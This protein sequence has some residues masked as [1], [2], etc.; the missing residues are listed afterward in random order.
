MH[1]NIK[2][3]FFFPILRRSDGG[4]DLDRVRSCGW[5][6]EGGLLRRLP[7]LVCLPRPRFHLIKLFSWDK[8]SRCVL[9]VLSSS[10]KKVPH[11]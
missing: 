2:K 6:G 7:I 1:Q 11:Q 4:T 10:G 5:M 3:S 9:S 8:Q